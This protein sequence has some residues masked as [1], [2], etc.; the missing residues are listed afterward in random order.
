[1]EETLSFLENY[2]NDTLPHQSVAI[3]LSYLQLKSNFGLDIKEIIQ[4]E[5]KFKVIS[6]IMD[7][8]EAVFLP[9]YHDYFVE[10]KIILNF[11][12][13]FQPKKTYLALIGTDGSAVLY[14]VSEMDFSNL[15]VEDEPV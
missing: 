4:M 10:N 13:Q 14:Q 7:N 1:M 6:G 11:I 9:L 5:S 15:K 3:P 8:E 12:K 2:E